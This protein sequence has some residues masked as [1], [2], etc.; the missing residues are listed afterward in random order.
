MIINKDLFPENA[1]FGCGH[2]N[3]HGMRIEIRQAPDG[4][5]GLVG[6]FVPRPHMSGFPG[7]THGGAIYS[8]LDCLAAWTPTILKPQERAIWILRSASI[9]YL[10]PTYPGTK[11]AL[12]TEI[13]GDGTPLEVRAKA[14]DES[15]GLLVRATFKVVSLSPERFVEVAG[16]DEFPEEWNKFLDAAGGLE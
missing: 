6:T 12:E 11:V 5:V 8:A 2:E 7:I 15:G 3:E 16:L 13:T 14:C 10:R 4:V 1:C 9:K